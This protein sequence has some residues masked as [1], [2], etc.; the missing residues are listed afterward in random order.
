MLKFWDHRG[1]LGINARNLLYIK[2][3]N[4]KAQIKFADDKMRTKQY[5]SARRI[6]TAR[7]LGKITSETELLNFQWDSLPQDFVLKPNA[8]FGGEGIVVIKNREEGGWVTVKGEFFSHEDMVEHVTD[9]LDGRYS[10]TNSPDTVFFEER[11]MCHHDMSELGKF[12]LPDIRIIVYNLVPVMAMVRVP[13][14]ESKGKANVHMGGLALGIDLAKGEVTHICHHNKII[15]SHPDF[16]KLQ[17]LKI[18]FWDEVLLLATQIQQLITLGYLAVDIVI[19]EN[20]GPALLEI[21]ARAGLNVQIANLAP[22][23]DRLDRVAGVKVQ[24]AEKGVRLAQDLFGNKIERSIQEISG[25][26]VIG[27]EE[28]IILNLKNGTQ[29]VLAKMNPTMTKNYLDSTLFQKIVGQGN[30]VENL[31]LGYSLAG[32]RG[33][34]MFHSLEMK[35]GGH[36]VILGKKALSNFFL[37]VTRSNEEKKIPSIDHV[38][39][40]KPQKKIDSVMDRLIKID[41]QLADWDRALGLVSYLRPENLDEEK[42]RFFSSREYQ[43]QFRYKSP[44]DGLINVRS[45]LQNLAIPQKRPIGVLLEQK[46]QELINK[47][48]LIQVIGDDDHF[49][50][51]SRM[52]L[53]F[54]P[55]DVISAALED[56]ARIQ[57]PP[58]REKNISSEQLAE[59]MQAYLKKKGLYNWEVKL[60]QGIVSRCVLGKNNRL[61]VKSGEMFSD[62]DLQKLIAH[63]IE[64]HIYCTE[65]GKQQPFQIFRRGTAGYLKTQEGLA[66]YHQSEVVDGGVRNAVIGLNAVVWAQTMSF[67]EIYN[68]GLEYLDQ[69]DAWKLAV[70]VKRGMNDTSKPGGFTKNAL[71]YWGYR[72]IAQY[73][74][75]DGEYRDL[76]LG[77]FEL[78]Q[79]DLIR[80]MKDLVKPQI[81]PEKMS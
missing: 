43:P 75:N 24:T 39:E 70:K 33:K 35:E 37:D 51:Q 77:K 69:N 71:Y 36:Q 52:A 40:E 20:L 65:N 2:P 56:L 30:D 7:L 38:P 64:T 67:R 68:K 16:G 29:P 45:K 31:T 57:E 61:L 59:R 76:F 32:E 50:K 66:V 15:K 18:P 19:D 1:V 79:L 22:L 25:K 34:T 27:M 4:K 17:G 13:T 73:L 42:K 60:K 49:P 41:N 72:E 48:S 53:G 54:P 47:S 63:E 8:G 81:L 46:R 80:Q 23:R 14:E 28:E 3:L 6:S 9:V 12:G 11:L 44:D 26:S 5:L 74:E 10:I 21:N 58:Q 62:Y 55:E 78:S